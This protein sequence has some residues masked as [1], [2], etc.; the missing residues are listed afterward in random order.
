MKIQEIHHAT[1][2]V[3][4]SCSALMITT[5]MALALDLSLIP[6]VCYSCRLSRSDV[7]ILSTSHFK[8]RL[9][10]D[11]FGSLGRL[12]APGR[13][14]TKSLPAFYVNPRS[15][16]PRFVASR[17]ICQMLYVWDMRVNR[18]MGQ[19]VRYRRR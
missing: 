4:Q 8:T 6:K 5:D 7:R 9:A 17:W 12:L 3:L 14:I 2:S 18:N 10:I 16:A 1:R 15:D 13:I 19:Q 11:M